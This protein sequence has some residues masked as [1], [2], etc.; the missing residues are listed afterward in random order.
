MMVKR[1]TKLGCTISSTVLKLLAY[2]LIEQLNNTRVDYEDEQIYQN[3]LFYVDD[4]KIWPNKAK[5]HRAAYRQQQ[6]WLRN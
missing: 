4:D 5:M 3:V 1:G 6:N 2:I